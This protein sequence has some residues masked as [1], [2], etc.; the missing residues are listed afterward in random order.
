[1]ARKVHGICCI[2]GKESDLTFE[3]IPPRAAFNHFNLKLYDFWGYLTQNK[4]RYQSLQNG[5]GRYS[6]CA[7]C[8]NRTG[9]WYGA[10]FAEFVSQG[11]Q[12]YKSGATGIVGVPYT[13]Y[14]LRVLKQVAFQVLMAHNGVSSILLYGNFY[15]IQKN[16]VFLSISTLECICKV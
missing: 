16:I 2:C 4:T 12:Y 8:N 3:H 10:A 11:M 1:M 6:L 14:P 9:E 15:L 5:A 13:F 7:S